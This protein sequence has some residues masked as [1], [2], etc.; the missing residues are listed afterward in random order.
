[1]AS[2][3][4][5]SI[6]LLFRAKGATGELHQDTLVQLVRQ[7]S[8]MNEELGFSGNRS[9]R[10]PGLAWVEASVTITGA[11][12]GACRFIGLQGAMWE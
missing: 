4:D 6:V 10:V 11:V 12:N 7:N 3:E 5:V 9:E 1:M 8:K 2:T